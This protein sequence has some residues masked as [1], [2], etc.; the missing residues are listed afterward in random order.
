MTATAARDL[1]IVDFVAGQIKAANLKDT[2]SLHRLASELTSEIHMEAATEIAAEA[3][4]E[5]SA[6][7]AGLEAGAG[8]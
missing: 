1:G 6:E 5:A 7:A 4:A 8:K 3:F 2:E